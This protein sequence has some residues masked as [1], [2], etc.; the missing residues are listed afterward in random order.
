MIV[1]SKHCVCD[2]HS[3]VSFRIMI[4]IHFVL[5]AWSIG[6]LISVIFD[7]AFDWF[8]VCYFSSL[9]ILLYILTRTKRSI[10]R[11]LGEQFIEIIRMG[12]QGLKDWFLLLCGVTLCLFHTKDLRLLSVLSSNTDICLSM[13][14]I[15]LTLRDMMRNKRKYNRTIRGFVRRIRSLEES[16]VLGSALFL[17]MCFL[18]FASLRPRCS[19]RDWMCSLLSSSDWKTLKALESD[20]SS[21]IIR[22]SSFKQLLQLDIE[23]LLLNSKRHIH[24]I[25]FGW[26][27]EGLQNP[28]ILPW[29]K[30]W[31]SVFADFAV[32]ELFGFQV[33]IMTGK[34][35]YKCLQNV[36]KFLRFKPFQNLRYTAIWTLVSYY[37]GGVGIWMSS[38]LLSTFVEKVIVPQ[39]V[40]YFSDEAS[41]IRIYLTEDAV[42]FIGQFRRRIFKVFK[43][44]PYQ[45]LMDLGKILF[46]VLWLVA[47]F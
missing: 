44:P 30:L 3:K 4:N 32:N 38:H 47:Y 14:G 41:T 22:F 17:V 28:H 35:I 21:L 12:S 5:L 26:L 15:F 36:R 2:V 43:Y 1:D 42:I 9:M 34:F 29:V 11:E 7:K 25:L 8:L 37:T 45:R 13:F 31:I 16:E 40:D 19:L 46:I 27:P 24:L 18:V 20:W 23:D 10:V 6:I 33:Y 39:I